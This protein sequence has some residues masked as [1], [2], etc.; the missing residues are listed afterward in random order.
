MQSYEENMENKAQHPESPPA[1]VPQDSATYPTAS[2]PSTAGVLVPT[3]YPAPGPQQ[4]PPLLQYPPQP[5]YGTHQYIVLPPAQQPV[6][7]QQVPSYVGHIVFACL[8]LWLCDPLF[9]LI[10]FILAS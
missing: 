2:G 7:V 5:G 10:A 4:Y 1:Y 3:Q 8:V 6:I 9:G